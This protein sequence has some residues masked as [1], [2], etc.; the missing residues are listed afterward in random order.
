MTD[1]YSQ[2]RMAASLLKVGLGKVWMDP[3]KAEEIAD[4]ITRDDVRGLI[5]SGTIRKVF[6]RGASRGRWRAFKEL[7]DYGHRKGPGSRKGARG[8]RTGH[9]RP[10]V[11]RIR[12]Q[13]ARLR[14]LRDAGALPRNLYRNLYR[15]ASGGQFRNLAHLNQTLEGLGVREPPPK[16]RRLRKRREPKPA[17]KR[18]AEPP[19]PRRA[20]KRGKSGKPARR[21]P[22][23][24]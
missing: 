6:P 21:S 1:L 23:G 4:A 5:E 19:A 8:V 17:S 2:R 15:R 18:A 12:L 13:R 9:K 14:S 11:K 7:R 16:A 3:E 24:S 20:E 22:G 10:W